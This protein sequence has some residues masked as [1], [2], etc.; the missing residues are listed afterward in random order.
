M[1]IFD[2]EDMKWAMSVFDV[3]KVVYP[4]PVEDDNEDNPSHK[5]DF[6]PNQETL[7]AME[8]AE[9]IA[10]GKIEIRSYKTFDD[11]WSDMCE[12]KNS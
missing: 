2:E 7:D 10:S 3:G 8:E 5:L 12:T 6:I 4:V 1:V 11:M 9:A